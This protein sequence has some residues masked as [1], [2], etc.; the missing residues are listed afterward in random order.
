[1]YP[2][3]DPHALLFICE[4]KAKCWFGSE[5]MLQSG[6]SLEEQ[7]DAEA[8]AWPIFRWGCKMRFLRSSIT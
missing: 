8:T 5:D 2:Y 6:V 7:S 3:I 4:L 1:M